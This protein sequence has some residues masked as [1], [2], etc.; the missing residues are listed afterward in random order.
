MVGVL[1]ARVLLSLC[2]NRIVVS[3]HVEPKSGPKVCACEIFCRKVF[4]VI[5]KR[6]LDFARKDTGDEKKTG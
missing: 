5:S 2:R 4:F 1:F 6:F 3:G